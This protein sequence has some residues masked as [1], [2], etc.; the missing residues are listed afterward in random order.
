MADINKRF[1][2]WALRT[3]PGRVKATLDSK[4]EDTLRRYMDAVTRLCSMEAK[5]R[6]TL[7][8]HGVQT[9]NYV[10]YLDFARQLYKL[11][12]MQE[13]TGESF[14][15]AAQVLLEKWASRGLNPD[16]LASVR[17]QVFDIGEP[18]QP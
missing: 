11:T 1:Q 17:H 14:A 16:V 4:R 13:I 10:A 15:V 9:I 12:R 5:V 2:N 7:N 6:E 18:T 3:E 8:A